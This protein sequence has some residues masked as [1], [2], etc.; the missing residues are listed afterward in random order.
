MKV[1]V[2]WVDRPVK[3]GLYW[4]SPFCGG[5]YIPP[6]IVRLVDYGHNRK[7]IDDGGSYI[8]LGVYLREYYPKAKY[9]FIPE[10]ICPS[11]RGV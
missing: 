1:T 3:R 4:R 2:K 6:S 11:P 5:R 7:D 9:S 10:P 8:K